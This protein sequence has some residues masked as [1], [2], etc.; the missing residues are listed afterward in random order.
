LEKFGKQSV[1]E[2]TEELDPLEGRFESHA[3]GNAIQISWDMSR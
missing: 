1:L 3:I 2:G